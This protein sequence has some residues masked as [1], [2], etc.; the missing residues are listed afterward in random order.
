LVY[1]IWQKILPCP[2]IVDVHN[3]IT[4]VKSK[5]KFQVLTLVFLMLCLLGLTQNPEQQTPL[6][7]GMHSISSHNLLDH[8]IE[9]SSEKY[10]GRLTGSAGYDSAA[11]W[12]SGF[13]KKYQLTPAGDK[14]SYFQKFAIPYTEVFPGAEVSLSVPYGRDTIIKHYRYVSEFIP[15][16]K[17]N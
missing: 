6:I 11:R 5:Q 2:S 12:V 13:F 8:V 15:R 17:E 16:K 1:I 14:R 3:K 7:A 4:S 9:L 10:G